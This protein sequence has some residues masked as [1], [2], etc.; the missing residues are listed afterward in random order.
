[1]SL[2]IV[3][4]LY[5]P[6][7]YVAQIAELNRQL[8]PEAALEHTQ[9]RV[10]ALPK[11]DRILLAVEGDRLLGYAHIRITRDLLSDEAAEVVTLAVAPDHRRKGVGRRLVHAAEAW[12]RESGRSRLV[13]RTNVVVTAAHAFFVALGYAQAETS[14]VFVR[15]LEVERRADQPTQPL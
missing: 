4:T 5:P 6:E 14:L 13:L 3:R 1:M 15:D 12:A 11:E 9:R 7:H 10:R 8:S 2:Q